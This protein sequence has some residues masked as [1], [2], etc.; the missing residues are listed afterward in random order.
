MVDIHIARMTE[1]FAVEALCW[2][3]EKPYDFYNNILTTSAIVEL[4]GGD[5]Y[6]L[7]DSSH[8]LVGF[9]CTGKSAKV[10]SGERNA[11]YL[12]DCVDLGLGMNPDLT[13]K[14]LGD[15]FLQ[16]ILRFIE[17]EHQEKDIRLTVAT[18]NERA[19]RLYEKNHFIR[20]HRFYYKETEF[21]TMKRKNT[22]GQG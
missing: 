14:G 4:L 15:Q 6:A 13:G 11:A 9:F 17:R 1:K 3:Y 16:R 7:V 20:E 19:I 10:P 8:K 5:Y 22:I 18:F 2:K 21:I 12:E